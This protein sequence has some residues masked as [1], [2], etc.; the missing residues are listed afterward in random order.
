MIPI[1]RRSLLAAPAALLTPQPGRSKSGLLDRVRVGAEF[2]LNRSETRASIDHHFR[3]M[4]E[5]GF[6][7][8]RI[9]TIWDDVERTQGQ[10]D[11]SRYDWIYDAAARNGIQIANT[12]CAEDPPGWMGTVGF[13]H[14]WM[15]LSHPKLRPHA[16][17]Y[18]EKL[19]TR[20]RQHPAHG[21]WLL[22]N[23]P[24]FRE[25]GGQHL[26][27]LF[28]RWLRSKYGNVEALNRRWY[29]PLQRFEDVPFPIEPRVGGW[30]DYPS[31]L[32]WRR[33]WIDHL[34]QQQHWLRAQVER[35]H[36][37]ALTHIGPPGATRNMPAGG[38]DPWRLKAAAHFLGSSMH[39]SWAYGDF[40]REDFGVAHGF[41]CDLIRSASAP[42]PYW[43]TEM[44]AGPTMLTGSRPLNPTAAEITR[45]LWDGFGNGARATVFWLWHPR[46]EGNE[47][48][49]WGLAGP[50]GEDTPRTRAAQAVAGVLRANDEFFSAAKP[51]PARSAILYSPETLVLHALE[52]WRSP[53]QD[54]MQSLLGC[55][56][57]LHGAHVAVDFLHTTQ[58]EAG[59]AGR[60]R[61]LYLPYCY[62]LSAQSAA[63]LRRFVENGGTLWADG[64]VAWKNENGETAAMPPGP[65]ADVFGFTLED[66]D[67]VWSPYSLG[68]G[69]DQAGQSWRCLIPASKA[70]A[71]LRAPDGR[72]TAVENRFGKGRALYYGGALTLAALLRK[73]PP[74]ESWIASPAVEAAAGVPVRLLRAPDRVSFRALESERYFAAVLNNWGEA[75]AAAVAF[76]PGT[77]SVTD[78]LSRRSV[79]CR[80][81][82]ASAVAEW[83]LAAGGSA[84]LQAKR[85]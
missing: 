22:Q 72:V 66:I 51:I 5:L 19:V 59:A 7:V 1:S 36:P 37:G 82:G 58:L 39:A 60:Y 55:Y 34:V 33:F 53:N 12:L 73:S 8:A 35:H 41:C 48:G 26:L 18:I 10:W 9:F 21:V 32:D 2:F 17:I 71:L 76:P 42:G 20:Y 56:R 84:L 47:A 62:A 68:P 45:W 46:T 64:L 52:T 11:F 31:L 15:D 85:G 83:P 13:Y 28:A 16:E 25:S 81:E 80:A 61:V 65:L 75:G 54:A 3:R 79:N 23:E 29:R 4:G 77:Q 67:A 69:A 40:A 44:Q 14:Q 78:L 50:N 6:T 43:V 74:A 38:R 27:P 24:G 70:R 57:A 30:A 49:E 63:A